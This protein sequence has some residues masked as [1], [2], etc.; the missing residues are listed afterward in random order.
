MKR[1]IL[2]TMLVLGL[3]G[4]LV[5]GQNK[6]GT[7]SSNQTWSGII[8]IVGNVVIQN[9]VV[10]IQPGTQVRFSTYPADITLAIKSGG[11]IKAIGTASSK[12]LFT[13][14]STS[15]TPGR[16]GEI[17]IM[18]NI[19]VSQTT[20]KYCIFECGQN[21]LDFRSTDH[22]RVKATSAITI[23]NCEIRTME[24]SGFYI[25][26][27]G[28][29]TIR[30]C[31]FHD[32]TSAGIFAHGGGTIK[33]YYTTIYN[34]STGI[35][36]IGEPSWGWNQNMTVDHV[37]IHH[38]DGDLSNTDKWWT[39]F[40]IYCGGSEQWA[41]LTLTNT[42][43]SDVTYKSNPHD[44]SAGP[45]GLECGAGTVTNDYNCWYQAGYRDINKGD[46]GPHAVE[47]N[48][49]FN[50]PGAG[51]LSLK[52]GS[53]CLN[54]ASDGTHIGAWQGTAGIRENKVA[55]GLDREVQVH[56]GN[57]QVTFYLP[58]GFDRLGI[59]S[60]DGQLVWMFDNSAG[61][62]ITWQG[63]TGNGEKAAKGI[64]IYRAFS[65]GQTQQNTILLK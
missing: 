4:S 5:W 14:S 44:K 28:S 63:L 32:L 56:S 11:A 38:V 41:N 30:N 25:T 8:N 55:A 1:N 6:S 10:T 57:C 7:I 42:I 31:V 23:E 58:E 59:Y 9:A 37:T 53:P 64:Y 21:A 39:G 62:E 47:A 20:F 22:D 33:I 27:G 54:K 50:N 52:Y 18:E 46:P 45:I 15:K 12:I 19:N 2:T 51:D 29:P 40:G 13:T 35:I 26:A 60:L 34:V 24:R 61:N 16:W 49:L 3:A 43:V 48:P 65:V 17:D 36:N